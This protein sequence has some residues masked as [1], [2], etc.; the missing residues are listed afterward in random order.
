MK[1]SESVNLEWA[2]FRAAYLLKRE[3]IFKAAGGPEYVRGLTNNNLAHLYV[4]ALLSKHQ[5]SVFNIAY[6]ASMLTEI[7]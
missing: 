7:K 3:L 2:K 1:N 4:S 5:G 6:S